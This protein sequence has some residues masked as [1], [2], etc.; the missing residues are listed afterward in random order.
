LI[1][2]LG[3]SPPCPFLIDPGPPGRLPYGAGLSCCASSRRPAS[4]SSLAP[5]GLQSLTPSRLRRCA[6]RLPPGGSLREPPPRGLGVPLGRRTGQ[7]LTG[8][9]WRTGR[10][11]F[12]RESRKRG[13]DSVVC[14]RWC[15]E[16]ATRVAALHRSLRLDSS[17]WCPPAGL[18]RSRAGLRPEI[19]T[20]SV[21]ACGCAPR[22]ASGFTLD[23]ARPAC[24][25]TPRR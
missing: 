16:S 2:F 21:L 24:P 9:A 13:S 3:P 25:W 18:L 7:A 23:R 10:A 5:G 20:R 6:L 12:A 15:A 19:L 11:T 14:R 22:A 1:V 4:R 17:S 8:W